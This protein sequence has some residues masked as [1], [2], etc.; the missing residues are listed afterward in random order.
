[1]LQN[2]FEE[3]IGRSVSEQ[4]YVE[5]NAVYEAAGDMDKDEFCREWVKIGSSRLVRC[6]ADSCHGLAKDVAER[7][8]EVEKC[9]GMISSVGDFLLDQ[10]D[11][12]HDEGFE[13]EARWLLGEH[14]VIVRKLRRGMSLTD[15]ERDFIEEC[16]S[17]SL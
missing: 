16:L 14:E 5:A 4:E 13:D 11:N 8:H 6:L 7:E 9:L 3:R 15:V 2:E 10:R 12:Y 1:M 17:R